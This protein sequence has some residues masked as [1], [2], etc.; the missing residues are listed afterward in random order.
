M[1]QEAFAL[2][3][4]NQDVLTCIAN[5][6][7]D[8]V[9]TPPNLASQ[10]LDELEKAWSK[11]NNGEN[12]WANSEVKF[13]DP[14]TKSGVFL[15]EITK[16]LIQGLNKQIPDLTERV[17]HILANQVYG[18]AT[19]ELTSLLARR[20]LYCAKEANGIHSV[21]RT[22]TNRQGNVW[23]ERVEH[24]WKNGRCSFCGAAESE[25]SRG[26]ENE[27]YAYKFI[28]AKDPNKLIS[29][30]FG[31]DMNFDVVIGNPPY[32]LETGGSGR[33]A[34]PIYNLFVEQAKALSPRFLTM[35][36]PSRWFAGGMGLDEFRNN[37]LN[38]RQI[39][40]LVDYI[41]AGD[42]FPEV[43]VP[44]GVCYFLWEKD[45]NGDCKVKNIAKG[46][47]YE[48]VRAL[49]QFD[50]FVRH[51][52]AVS[53]LT[54]VMA[55]KEKSITEIVSST[56]PFGL[57][58]KDRPDGKGPIRLVSSGG[59]GKIALSR[60]TAGKELIGKWK[61]LT[62][63]TSHDHGGNP[64]KQGMRRVLSRLEILEPN[65]VCTESYIVVGAF[66]TEEEAANCLSYLQTR[67]ARH[68]ISILS[69]SQDITRERFRYV[70]L[71]D[72]S[73]AWSDKALYKKYKIT[74]EEI[75]FIESVIKEMV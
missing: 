9:F 24:E 36:I 58:T 12:I 46:I 55:A 66:D 28:H 2:R 72:F 61:V 51:S 75:Q 39:T 32:Q 74:E 38:D 13:L 69:F 14:C 45:F 7:N 26:E 10:L 62:S 40:H 70:P 60:V 41:D 17:N 3:S 33:Q 65:A 20:S 6:S 48:S 50:T 15:R 63:K 23:H 56:R 52:A 19:T 25:Y 64:D 59:E 68:L 35:I 53:I 73:K 4:Y 18:I 34:K 22:F 67:F 54:K 47:E 37:M 42:L 49:N 27:T 57:Q 1:T 71:Q 29:E 8:E 16:R 44:G 11:A 31:G 21:A 5:L 30:T 43:D